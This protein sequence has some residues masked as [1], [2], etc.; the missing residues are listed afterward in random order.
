MY[1][2]KNIAYCLVAGLLLSCGSKMTDEEIASIGIKTCQAQPAYV[3]TA[4]LN[5][6]RS[7]LS[8]SEKKIMGL[9]LV[10][11]PANPADMANRKTWQHPSWKAFGWMGPITTDDK[12]NAYTA[13]VPLINLLNNPT[14]KQNI[15]YKVSGNTGEMQ[16][17]ADLPREAP[18]MPDNPYGILG[19]YYDCHAGKL[20]ASS[21]AG[22]ARDKERG[23]IY[24]LDPETG[25]IEDKLE[26]VDA[27]GLCT[28]GVT[29][30]KKLY[31]GSSRSPDIYAVELDKSGR[32]TGSPQ[33]AYSLDM[34]GPR[35]D[36]KARRIRFDRN[37]DMLVSGVEFNFNLTAPTEKQETS[38]RF[39]YDEETKSWRNI[40]Q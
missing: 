11:I 27:L 15:V 25:K 37:G 40:M 28:G 35:G 19:L 29:G 26:G 20:Y 8:T 6:S 5:P 22:S 14:D 7:A 31:Y 3:R 10:E 2:K 18:V 39:R 33:K 24:M 1:M 23:V 12:G 9:V 36:D 21:V 16:V 38:Y 17:L 4:G 34:L 30:T 13:P 32:F